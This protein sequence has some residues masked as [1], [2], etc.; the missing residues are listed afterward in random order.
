MNVL[1]HALVGNAGTGGIFRD[2]TL[3]P[4]GKIRLAWQVMHNNGN[5][6]DA[7]NVDSASMNTNSMR[8]LTDTQRTNFINFVNSLTP[9]NGTPSHLMFQQA[10]DY[11]RRTLSAN[12]PW[13]SKPGTTGAPYLACRRSYHIMMT[14]GRWNGTASGGSQDDNTQ[15]LT[16][17]DGTIYGS[18]STASR[19]SNKLYSDSF[20]DTLADWAFKSWAVPAQTSGMTGTMQPT[21]DY[22]KAP[23]TEN[24]AT[25]TAPA[26]AV[27]DRYWN[28][29]YNPATWPHMVTYTIGFS[30]MAST[31]PGANAIIKPSQTVPFG[32]DGSFPNFVTGTQTWPRMDAENKR[33]LDLWHA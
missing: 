17:P 18:T 13:A 22:R 8:S 12:S 31:W 23:A 16:L 2:T 24:F 32:Y 27:L 4:E 30:Q 6:S 29:R 3:L 25:P 33:S 7:K 28:P 20:S 1:K 19:P 5:A 26:S 14:D 9:R 10:D 11:M 15:N 21:A